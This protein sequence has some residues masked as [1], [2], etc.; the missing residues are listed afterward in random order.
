MAKIQR[1]VDDLTVRLAAATSH[2]D[3]AGI[4]AELADA[5][6]GL[7]E[8]EQRWLEIADQLG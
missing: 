1:R 6:Q 8:H 4:G 2:A 3:L 5:Q 7:A